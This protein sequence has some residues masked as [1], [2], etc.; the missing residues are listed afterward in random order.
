MKDFSINASV[1][2]RSGAPK[3]SQRSPRPDLIGTRDDK[4]Q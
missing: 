4:N 1:I 2:A 3:Q